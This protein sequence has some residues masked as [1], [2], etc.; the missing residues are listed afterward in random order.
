MN[1]RQQT[2]RNRGGIVILKHQRVG[3]RPVARFEFLLLS[4][5]RMRN[6]SSSSETDAQFELS[7]QIEQERIPMSRIPFFD[8]ESTVLSPASRLV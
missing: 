6:R 1:P 4:S 3:A 7:H 2:F 5:F 8:G